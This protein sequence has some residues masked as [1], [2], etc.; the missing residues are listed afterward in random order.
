MAK[1]KDWKMSHVALSWLKSKGISS[2]IIGFSKV[3]RIDE[4]LETRGKELTQEEV[5]YL[6]EPYV[7]KNIIGHS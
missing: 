5:K 4:A 2:P 1:K 3:E 7:P 6:E